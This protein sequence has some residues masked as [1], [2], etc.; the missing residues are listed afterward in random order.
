MNM[1]RFSC[2]IDRSRTITSLIDRI[3]ALLARARDRV[4]LLRSRVG[5][6][7]Y[8]VA[9]GTN[10]RVFHPALVTNACKSLQIS[11]V[12]KVIVNR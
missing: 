4:A 9:V 2:L 8:L 5:S 1:Q 11:F 6:H 10:P 12:H 7:F 3:P